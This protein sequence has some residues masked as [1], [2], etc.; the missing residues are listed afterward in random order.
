MQIHG[1]DNDEAFSP[2]TRFTSIRT[3]L[4]KAAN[5]KVQIHQ[6]DI[7]GISECTNR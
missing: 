6:M 7:G 4:Q 1:L 2:A 5:E 3:L